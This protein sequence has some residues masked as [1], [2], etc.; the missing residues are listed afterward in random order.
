MILCQKF[1]HFNYLWGLFFLSLFSC[2]G[3]IGPQKTSSPPLKDPFLSNC[4]SQEIDQFQKQKARLDKI[5]S[6]Y[7]FLGQSVTGPLNFSPDQAMKINTSIIDH[8][9]DYL[10]RLLLKGAPLG[11]S[12]R[13]FNTIK[14]MLN[15]WQARVCQKT[16][17]VERQEYDGRAFLTIKAMKDAN[18]PL[19]RG[20]LVMELASDL[21]AKF[22]SR[23]ICL[24]EALFYQRQGSLRDFVDHWYQKFEKKIW[25]KMFI[26]RH[27]NNLINCEQEGDKL[28]LQ[29]P[30]SLAELPASWP[31]NAE[32]IKEA[33]ESK[34]SYSNLEVQVFWDEQG[35]LLEEAKNNISHVHGLGQ[36]SIY[37]GRQVKTKDRARLV[38]AHEIGHSLGFPDCYVEFYDRDTREL[39]YYELDRDD[40]MCSFQGQH[41]LGEKRFKQLKSHY[42]AFNDLM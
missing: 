4:S 6:K 42:C 24:S 23:T 5:K 13:S 38:I 36:R 8:A 15:R 9:L 22:K 31:L 40:L 17:M 37:L 7:G 18:Q 30:L 25:R 33:I 34:W 10:E 3:P 20:Q 19:N 16:Q 12:L 21:C 14:H 29:I 35:I 1:R 39:I 26:I 41:E 32:E 2:I 11:E 28:I 27:K